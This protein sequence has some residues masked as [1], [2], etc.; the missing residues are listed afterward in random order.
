[1]LNASEQATGTILQNNIQDLKNGLTQM[2]V[3][4]GTFQMGDQYNEESGSG[5]DDSPKRSKY[6]LKLPEEEIPAFLG[7]SSYFSHDGSGGR[8]NV[9]V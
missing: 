7:I 9:S 8:I 1:M 5:R 4:C 3:A 6:G 2:G